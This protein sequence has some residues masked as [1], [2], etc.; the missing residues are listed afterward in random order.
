MKPSQLVEWLRRSE[1]EHMARF[2]EA[3]LIKHLDG[4]LEVIGGSP[5]D[6]TAAKEWIS[7]F[8][9]NAV[10]TFVPPRAPRPPEPPPRQA[11]NA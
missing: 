7:L 3:R 6:H 2:G 5:A 10:V 1:P 9:H 8:L 4:K 11:D